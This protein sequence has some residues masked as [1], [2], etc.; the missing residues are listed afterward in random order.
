MSAKSILLSLTGAAIVSVLASQVQGEVKA[1]KIDRPTS[2]PYE[3]DLSIFEG[4]NRAQELH[5]QRI[6]NLL[7]LKPGKNVADIGAGSGW[8]TVRAARRVKTGIVYAVE[9]NPA[10]I[11]YIRNRARKEK[12][13]NIR[14]I[15]ST[16]D[17]P[18]LPKAS[19][20]AALLLKTYHEVAQPIAL[21]RNL[22][23][24]LR[25]GALLGIIDRNGT[26]GDHG[27]NA[28]MVIKEARQAGFTL[29]AQYDFVKS[30]GVD[31]FLLFREAGRNR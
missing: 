29:V 27:I 10:A 26:G 14:L 4:A 9:I 19:V 20:D 17:D 8:F 3:G 31:Y 2:Q 25:S 5:V 16:T 30:E 11:D 28:D 12:L 7:G 23:P 22:R 18:L 6:I 13:L 15:Q 24:A 1:S 21:L